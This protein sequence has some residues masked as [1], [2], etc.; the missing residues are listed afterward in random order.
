MARAVIGAQI[1]E[2]LHARAEQLAGLQLFSRSIAASMFHSLTM[3][4]NAIE[5]V[6]ELMGAATVLSGV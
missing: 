1:Q 6:S 4:T 5:G 3:L 2:E